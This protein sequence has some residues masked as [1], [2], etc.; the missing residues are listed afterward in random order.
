MRARRRFGRPARDD[1]PGEHL[2]PSLCSFAKC[3]YNYFLIDQARGSVSRK[4]DRTI[5]GPNKR[6]LGLYPHCTSTSR[7]VTSL[8][9][10]RF[11]TRR[12]TKGIVTNHGMPVRW[13]TAHYRFSRA[14]CTATLYR[15]LSLA[16]SFASFRLSLSPFTSPAPTN[17]FPLSPTSPRFSSFSFPL[18]LP[19]C[20][21]TAPS[22]S[23]VHTL[24]RGTT[25]RRG[26][27]AAF[28]PCPSRVVPLSVTITDFSRLLRRR[29]SP[30][31]PQITPPPR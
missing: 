25:G 7:N 12:R 30:P 22:H 15:P 14:P 2:S 11:S 5:K 28:P 24:P 18:S 31:P 20:R 29:F 21:I 1:L 26:T 27:R 17:D 3:V 10:V 19:L 4:L 6:P 8:M 23:R 16:C 13:S 9:T